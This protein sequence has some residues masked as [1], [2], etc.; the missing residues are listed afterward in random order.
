M[1]TVLSTK[2]KIGGTEFRVRKQKDADVSDDISY[3]AVKE[4]GASIILERSA[5]LADADPKKK[6]REPLRVGEC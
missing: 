3:C 1:D 4:M 6:I 5:A 2:L